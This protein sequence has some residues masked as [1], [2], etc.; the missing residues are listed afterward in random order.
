MQCV[1]IEARQHLR[2][3]ERDKLM[4]GTCLICMESYDCMGD[5]H[6]MAGPSKQ[7]MLNFVVKLDLKQG[8]I[9]PLIMKEGAIGRHFLNNCR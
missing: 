2:D 9:L 3:S 7:G 4:G 8:R 5:S 1:C 6:E